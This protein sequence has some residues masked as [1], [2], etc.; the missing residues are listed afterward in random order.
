MIGSSG[1]RGIVK[2]GV[3]IYNNCFGGECEVLL[4]IKASPCGDRYLQYDDIYEINHIL[5][6]YGHL[7]DRFPLG[8]CILRDSWLTWIVCHVKII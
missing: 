8:S 2:R 3:Y 1:G 6:N 5:K 7:S 4:K